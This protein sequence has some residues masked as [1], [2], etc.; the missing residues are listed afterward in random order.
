MKRPDAEI[1]RAHEVHPVTL[2]NWKK[3]LKENGPKAFGGDNEL[4]E[5]EKKIALSKNF[6]G[7]SSPDFCVIGVLPGL[8]IRRQQPLVVVSVSSRNQ[9]GPA[10]YRVGSVSSWLFPSKNLSMIK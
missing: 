2:S 10:P 4:K 8:H 1:A 9:V 3:K 5:K 7:G 6:L